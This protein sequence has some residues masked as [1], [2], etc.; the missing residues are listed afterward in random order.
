[1][2]ASRMAADSS[3]TCAREA[4]LRVNRITPA[5]ASCCSQSRSCAVRRVPAMPMTSMVFSLGC[6][7]RAFGPAPLRVRP[8]GQCQIVV[9]R[10]VG[11]FIADPV[12]TF[13]GF[14]GMSKLDLGHHQAG[15][16][17]EELVH[18]PQVAAMAHEV[19]A[20]FH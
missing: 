7:A 1:G 13:E 3:A 5:Q 19:A 11:G 12:R 4:K 14:V 8:R 17:A 6:R 20:L 9:A 18:L 10:A 2:A 16:G 15:V